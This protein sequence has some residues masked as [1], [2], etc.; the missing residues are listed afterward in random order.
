VSDPLEASKK[1]DDLL[2]QPLRSTMPEM[3]GRR[4]AGTFSATMQ[5]MRESVDKA[6]SDA[7][8]GIQSATDEL[9]GTIKSGGEKVRR[10]IVRESDEVRRSYGEM[11]GNDAETGEKEAPLKTDTTPKTEETPSD[12]PTQQPLASGGSG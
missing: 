11:L 5:V 6:I 7:S 4:F 12:P 2:R 9:V 1:L 10:A 8:K 3:G